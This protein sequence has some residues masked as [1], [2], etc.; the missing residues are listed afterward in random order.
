M[1][2][3][4]ATLERAIADRDQAEA[5]KAELANK[6]AAIAARIEGLQSEV[7]RAEPFRAERST[8]GGER[9]GLIVTL[10]QLDSGRRQ[11]ERA[12]AQTDARIEQLRAAAAERDRL[13]ELLAGAAVELGQLRRLVQAFGVTGIPARVIEGVLP[14]LASYANELLGELRPGMTLELRAQRAKKDGKGLVEALDLVVRDAAGER[15]LAL[16]SGG[17]KTSVSLA[18]AVAL[19]RLVARRAG[20]RISLLVVDEPDGLDTEARRAFGMALRVIAHH[21]ELERVVLVSHHPD[22]A[23]YADEVYEVTKGP[24]GSA[25]ELIS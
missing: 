17:E 18:L 23:E 6:G 3:A 12:I 10:D 5:E 20:A 7:A 15:P 24:A 8:A 14:E 13:A 21:G 25:V 22:L 19:S 1:A 2:A 4:Q 9:E 11:L 16:F